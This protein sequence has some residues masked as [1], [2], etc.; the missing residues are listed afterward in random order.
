MAIIEAHELIVYEKFELM[1]TRRAKA[2]MQ[3]RFSSLDENWGVQAKLIY[4]Y[5][6]L[7]LD[8]ITIVAWRHLV[9]DIHLCR[10]LKSSKNSQ[11]PLFWRSG[12]FKVSEIGTNQE[13][14]YDFLLVINSNLGP[15]SHCYWDTATYWS[16]IANFA[17]PPS[18]LAPSF[19]MTPFEFME[20]FYGFW[21]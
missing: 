15:I 13:P 2:Y 18:H 21:N 11:N 6:I 4:K 7:Y 3:F 1:L 16:K 17:H 10:S 19:G 9:N 5:Q 20:K 12:S 8:C 14:V